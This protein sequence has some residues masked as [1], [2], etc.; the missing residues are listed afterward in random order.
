MPQVDESI[1]C[2]EIVKVADKMTYPDL[3]DGTIVY[4]EC[5]THHPG[6]KTVCLDI[7]TLQVAYFAYKQMN[8]G[9]HHTDGETHK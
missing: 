3:F 7:W 6:F 5:I 8:D 9:E 2:H 1:C 4:H